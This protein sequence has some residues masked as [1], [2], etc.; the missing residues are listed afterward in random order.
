[1]NNSA[2]PDDALIGSVLLH[3][4]QQ[5]GLK[6]TAC[7]SDVARAVAPDAWRALMPRVRGVA[8]QLASQGIIEITQA[9]QRVSAKGPWKGPIR[10]RLAPPVDV[11]KPRGN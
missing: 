8:S 5:R 2:Q 7:P 3:L 11:A 1:V 4:V 9:G 10:L 6:A